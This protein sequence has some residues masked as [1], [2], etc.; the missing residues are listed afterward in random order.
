MGQSV[1]NNKTIKKAI[2]KKKQRL[3]TKKKFRKLN[4]SAN[5]EKQFTCYSKNSLEKIKKMWNKRHPDKVIYTNDSKEIWSELKNNLKDVCSSERCWIKQKFMENKLDSELL[6]NTHAPYAPKSW[7]E[8][9]N[10]WLSSNDIE[11]VMKQYEID[12]PNFI[13]I[14]PS[15]IDFDKKLMFGECV[16]N[17]LC[18]L[19]II[20]QLKDGKNKIGIIFNTDPHNKSGSHWI[21]LFIDIKRKFIFYFDSNGDKVP[22]EIMSLIE[23]IEKQGTEINI[24][25]TTYFNRKEHQYSNT[26]C[27]MYSLYFLNQMITTNKSPREFNSKRIPDKDVEELRKIYFN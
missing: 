13:F 2:K 20:K 17:E 24:D 14:G 3:K 5:K 19:N 15:P 10:E 26:E 9:P 7:K 23:R 1:R 25:F 4:C 16:W 18:N 21:S 8:N 6:N 22:R 12:Y 27:G 11:K